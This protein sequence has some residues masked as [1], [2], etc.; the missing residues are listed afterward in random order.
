MVR[1]PTLSSIVIIVQI[2]Y[3]LVI[4]SKIHVVNGYAALIID[5]DFLEQCK[6]YLN[7]VDKILRCWV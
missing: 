5:L 2:L 7:N 3:N 1:N 4:D 6:L